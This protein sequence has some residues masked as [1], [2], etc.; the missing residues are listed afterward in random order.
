MLSDGREART[1]LRPFLLQLVLLLL[2]LELLLGEHLV[3][4]AISVLGC[5]LL[6]VAQSPLPHLRRAA[7]VDGETTAS[8]YIQWRCWDE[9]RVRLDAEL[10]D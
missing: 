6:V 10:F 2:Q 9:C 3:P 4:N 8:S 1:L 5:P 7:L